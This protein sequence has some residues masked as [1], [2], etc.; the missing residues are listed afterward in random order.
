MRR[1]LTISEAFFLLI[2]FDATKFVL[3][4]FF[5]NITTAVTRICPKIW[6]KPLPKN[7]KSPLPVDVRRSKTPLLKLSDI[8]R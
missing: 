2:C 7:V 6:A 3:L 8:W 4:S 1:T 5:T